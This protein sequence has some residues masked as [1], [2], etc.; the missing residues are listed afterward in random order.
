MFFTGD[1]R[2]FSSVF[3]EWI[4]LSQVIDEFLK[5]DIIYMSNDN[6]YQKPLGN[7]NEQIIWIGNDN[8]EW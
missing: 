8:G 4:F 2:V 6:H 5:G 7:D 1:P 3:A